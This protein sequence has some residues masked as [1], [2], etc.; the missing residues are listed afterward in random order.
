MPGKGARAIDWPSEARLRRVNGR[1][2][3]RRSRDGATAQRREGEGGLDRGVVERGGESR[4]DVVSQHDV[5]RDTHDGRDDDAERLRIFD[6]GAAEAIV[7]AIG[8]L[9][10]RCLRKI[11]SRTYLWHQEVDRRPR[12]EDV[13]D[14]PHDEMAPQS[15]Q[16]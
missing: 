4:G 1:R 6:Q 12:Q 7:A 13:D 11:L 15:A 10:R 9:V 5:W 8:R 3:L 16:A 14:E 2:Q